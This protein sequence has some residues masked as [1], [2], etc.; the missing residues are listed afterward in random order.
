MSDRPV[1]KDA[2]Y[3]SHDK[4]R[5]QNIPAP[6]WILTRYRSNVPWTARPQES[7]SKQ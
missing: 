6:K 4:Y 7:A 5:R 3:T 1:A 2:I